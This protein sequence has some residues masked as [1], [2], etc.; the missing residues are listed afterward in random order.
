MSDVG[1]LSGRNE[2]SRDS[3]RLTARQEGHAATVQGTDASRHNGLRP[4]LLGGAAL[5]GLLALVLLALPTLAVPDFHFTDQDIAF[6]EAS[7]TIGETLAITVDIENEGDIDGANVVVNFYDGPVG[8]GLF[9]STSVD[10]A[11]GGGA[12]AFGNWT[13]VGPSG[14]RF[15]NVSVVAQGGET[16]VSDNSADA[17]VDVN[18]APVVSLSADQYTKQTLTNFAFSSAGTSDSDGL[19]NSYFWIFG[20]GTFSFN[21]NPS[22]QYDDNG[23]YVV[24][25]IATDDDGGTDSGSVSVNVTN[26][27]PSANAVDQTVQ[28][29]VNVK[30][31]GANSSDAD[32]FIQGYD[33][34]FHDGSHQL[35]KN[36]Q[37]MY[38]DDGVYSVTLTVTDD[39]GAIDQHTLS[40]TVLNRAPSADLLT[41][42]T[43]LNTTESVHF[44]A[45]DSGDPDGV[46]SNYTW[47]FPGGQLRY[48]V[49]LDYAFNLANGSYQVVLLVIDDDG[50]IDSATVQIKVGNRAPVAVGP[51]ALVG[52]TNENLDFDGTNS[53]DPDGILVNWSWD[54]VDG[55]PK[56]YGANATHAFSDD[57]LYN[58]RLT[59]RDDS[60]ATDWT[61]VAVTVN[62]LAPQA[63]HLNLSTETLTEVR[64][65]GTASTDSDGI[66]SQWAWDFHDGQPVQ[67][68]TAADEEATKTYNDDGVYRVTLSVTDDDGAVGITDF[69]VTVTNRPPVVD[70]DWQ[71][72]TST[73]PE[74]PI[75]GENVTFEAVDSL[76][77]DGTI[78]SFNWEYGDG[79]FG[80]GNQSQHIYFTE[81]AY[82]VTLQAIDDDGEGA[83]V[84]KLVIVDR[85]NLPPLAN[86]SIETG[87]ADRLTKSPIAFNGSS[88]T[89]PDGNITLFTW[90]FGDGSALKVSPAGATTH[91]YTTAGTYNVQ[92]TVT[93]DGTSLGTGVATS[94]ITKQIIVAARPNALP[95]AKG[96]APSSGLTDQSL[97]FDASA[98][99]DPDGA[100]VAYLWDFTDGVTLDSRVA[101]H[102][103]ADAKTYTV[104]LT[105]T[106][107]D[108][109]TN[110]STFSVT[111]SSPP[112]PNPPPE[113]VFAID[114]ASQVADTFQNV[115]FDAS[116]S[117]DADGIATISWLFGDGSS[118]VGTEVS[119]A[120]SEDGTFLVILTVI[121][122]KGGS[123]SAIKQ[124]T[125]RNQAP[126][127][128]IDG[129]TRFQ[130]K[131]TRTFSGSNST[132]VDGAIVTYQW[133]LS[134]A[135]STDTFDLLSTGTSPTVR[136]DFD[137]P[138]VY[139]LRLTVIDDSGAS[140]DAHVSITVENRPPVANAGENRE[141]TTSSDTAI[142]QLDGSRSVDPDGSVVTWKWTFDSDLVPV[143]GV[144]PSHA[145]SASKDGTVHKVILEVTDDK[146]ATATTEVQITVRKVDDGGPPK[147]PKPNHPTP[148]F[149]GPM[150]IGA[151]LAVLVLARRRRSETPR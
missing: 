5:L 98:S 58:V 97:T 59:V 80:T 105:V 25:L 50:A 65:N 113:A 124:M 31:S 16:D 49:V 33:W 21:P 3:G 135:G 88:S 6:A 117:S 12:E 76:D 67:I 96:S 62:N 2:R 48:G 107:D 8:V 127:P 128:Q 142:V 34:L 82:S 81:G 66:V 83:E 110:T 9:D 151:L 61:L 79:Q 19:I 101:T 91:I 72:D 146:G 116:A 68:T 41:N 99:I 149:E 71:W 100:I 53:Y 95:W 39:D 44:D 133:W 131:I 118:A 38:A 43:Q 104:K 93:D 46:I 10:I 37:Y 129:L 86:F 56:S 125:I 102:S 143:N 150:A 92:L 4:A 32:G 23:S 141:V 40:V 126:V 42:R 24:T 147:P 106:D 14:P 35:G 18:E 17:S 132:D 27:D 22:H 85:L 115:R 7:P 139:Q 36:V 119:H 47:I 138:G 109:A 103:F 55:T 84:T 75:A 26:R 29:L 87:L 140:A 69:W 20:D 89:D 63:I 77:L 15:L 108:S 112:P 136:V 145:L 45:D 130:S 111:I 137:R 1:G 11:A 120:Y 148:G 52:D 13:V 134:A 122:N 28:T 70:F 78:L 51:Q 114:P 90:D 123:A 121:D 94:V 54:F 30:F 57:G 73:S 60:G 64:V 74:T 144:N